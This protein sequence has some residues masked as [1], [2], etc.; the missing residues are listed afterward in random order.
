LSPFLRSSRFRSLSILIGALGVVA[1]AGACGSNAPSSTGSARSHDSSPLHP[2]GYR[3]VASEHQALPQGILP[4]ANP[5]PSADVSRFAPPVGDQGQI[6]DCTTWA[7]GYGLAGWLANEAGLDGGSNAF[8]PMFLFTHFAPAG[9]TDFGISARDAL[10]FMTASGID[11]AADYDAQMPTTFSKTPGA[12]IPGAGID[13]AANDTVDPPAAQVLQ[14]ALS[15]KLGAFQLVFDTPPQAD[16]GVCPGYPGGSAPIKA[17]IASGSPVVI[18]LPVPPEFDNYDGV[19]PVQPPTAT[20][21]SRGGHAILCTKY[22]PSGLWCENSWGVNWGAAGW[23][24]LSWAFVEQCIWETD[25]GLGFGGSQT[26]APATVSI[27]APMDGQTVSGSLPITIVVTPGPNPVTDVSVL[28]SG[29]VVG[30]ASSSG[31]SFTLTLDTT[32]L[33]NGSQPFTAVAT[34]SAGNTTTSD[35]VNVDVENASP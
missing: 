24:Q 16:P 9:S 18:A 25:T 3:Y 22:D 6:G 28:A 5:P 14:N 11:T 20:E 29:S 13:A 4:A 33:A 10:D 17:A 35:P 31:L 12:S 26:Q 23:V 21:V 32:Q 1:T 8:A 7:V 15:F 30:D 2:L 19:H 34:D 27:S